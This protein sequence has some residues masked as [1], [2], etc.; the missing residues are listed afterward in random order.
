MYISMKKH[1]LSNAIMMVAVIRI[2][3]AALEGFCRFIIKKSS[4]LF[5]IGYHHG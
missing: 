5:E 4:G 2:V 1:I 3:A